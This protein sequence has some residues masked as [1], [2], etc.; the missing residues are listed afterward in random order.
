MASQSCTQASRASAGCRAP[1]N[2]CAG[3]ALGSCAGHLRRWS[4]GIARRFRLRLL[5]PGGGVS[6]AASA[7]GKL[8][9]GGLGG[10]TRAPK[11][12]SLL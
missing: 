10:G 8:V 6:R 5:C 12:E 7:Q 2:P 11:K 4:S 9:I 1:G 3:S